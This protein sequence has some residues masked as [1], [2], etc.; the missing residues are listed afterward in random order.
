MSSPLL[1]SWDEVFT[2]ASV[3]CTNIQKTCGDKS[4]NPIKVFGIPKAGI[5][6]TMS[7]ALQN[8]RFFKIVESP[9]EADCFIDD[10]IDSGKTEAKWRESHPNKPFLALIDK[11]KLPDPVLRNQWISFPWD[12]ANNDA[13]P[14]ENIKR[15]LQFIGDDPMRDGLKD[16]PRRVVASYAEIFAGYKMDVKDC[17]TT[18]ERDGFDELVL[19]K[20]I[21]FFSCCVTGS[22]F[23][24]TPRGRIPIERLD[25]GEYIYCW[26][27]DNLKM[28]IRQAGH[29]RMTGQSKRLWRIHT[30]KDALLCTGNH[31]ILTHNRG[32]IK[33]RNL[34]A[35][36]SIVAL[37][38]G[39]R[40]Y[41]N[42]PRAMVNW[43][44]M[45]KQRPEHRFIYEEIC[46]EVDV[47]DHI[48]HGNHN[49]NDNRPEN[50]YR[51]GNG[52]HMRLHRLS[53]NG[54]TGFAIISNED[55]DEFKQR[56]IEGIKRSQ[57]EEVRQKRSESLKR[58]WDSM[59]PK[60]RRERNHRVLLVEKTKWK[61][62]VWC[63]DV[64][65]HHNFVANGMVVHNCEHHMLPFWGKA[66][67]AYIPGTSNTSRIIGASKLARI[68]EVYARRL[69]IQERIC[70]QVTQ[71]LR[72]HLKPLGSACIIEAVH[73]C[74]ACR[75]IKKQHSKLITSSLTGVFKEE[76]NQARLELLQLIKG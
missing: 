35:G 61:E 59:T 11:R 32:W 57:T 38:R 18:F 42:T 25:H 63:M 65:K 37:N 58:Y 21:E 49:A 53:E 47:E 66:H 39:C 71:A 74:I 75:G 45:K 13:G 54:K 64:P 19:L 68:L 3:V 28:T 70:Q 23:V 30:D 9:D 5:H 46:G 22:T 40:V 7:V 26:D 51:M 34:K 27:E 33:A 24:E 15:I 52:E 8:P 1:V 10:V 72:V 6:A 67:I 17:F 20:D 31:K 14:E 12:R 50:L 73:S 29:P 44:G 36:D 43:T 4:K 16:T 60:Q 56:Q 2:R 55:R 69:Q 48:H 41:Q 76:G 62:D